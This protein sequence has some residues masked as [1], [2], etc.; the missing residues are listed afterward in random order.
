VDRE[1]FEELNRADWRALELSLEVLEKGRSIGSAEEFPALYRKVCHHLA[2]V[3]HRRLGAD[4]EARLNGLVLRGHRQ[5]YKTRGQSG[6]RPWRLLLVDFPRRVRAEARLLLLA[7]LLFY[8]PFAGAFAAATLRSEVALSIM[9]GEQIESVAEQYGPDV[10]IPEE[11]GL[12]TGLY[13]FGFYVYNN[14]SI[15]F[16]TF[17]S[18]IFAGIGSIFFL[19]YNGLVIGAVSARI[20]SLGY[21]EA[22]YSF[23][24]GHGA[25]ELTA[26]VLAG[27]AGLRLGLAVVSPGRARRADALRVAAKNT[28]PILYGCAAMLLVAAAVEAFWSPSS[29]PPEIKIP[30][31]I[32]FWLGVGAFLVGAGRTAEA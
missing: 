12:G 11:R 24:V 13:M 18:G 6:P 30:V 25:F 7:S 3:R 23:I 8:G 27:V 17:A 32:L 22:F 31:G 16:R 20:R 21:D 14:V 26:I 1:R 5:L 10:L 19:V 9:P 15:A 2:L 28:M 29:V 4:L